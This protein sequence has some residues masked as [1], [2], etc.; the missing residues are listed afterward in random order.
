[1]KRTILQR[2]ERVVQTPW[3][4]TSV[5]VCRLNGK[6]QLYPEYESVAQLSRENEV[7]FTQIYNYL[8]RK[9]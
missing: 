1:M 3:G 6:E 5:K 7:P 8:V 9:K 4:E 2:E